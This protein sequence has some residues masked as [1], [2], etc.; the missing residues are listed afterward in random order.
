MEPIRFINFIVKNNLN[1]NPRGY[2]IASYLNYK[3]IYNH[4]FWFV[5]SEEKEKRIS[6]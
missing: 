1:I 6:L 2:S 4:K 5:Y 3:I